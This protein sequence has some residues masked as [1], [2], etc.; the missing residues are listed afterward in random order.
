MALD[1]LMCG[2]NYRFIVHYGRS[3]SYLWLPSQLKKTGIHH[4][5]MASSQKLIATYYLLF[6]QLIPLT[7]VVLLEM[8]K[9]HFTKN[10]ENDADMFLEDHFIKNARGCSV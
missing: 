1:G 5:A 8:G 6:N 2:L 9:L 7:L 3:L 10:I 4:V